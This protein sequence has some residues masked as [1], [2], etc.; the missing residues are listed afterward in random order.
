MLSGRGSGPSLDIY[1]LKLFFLEITAEAASY[2]IFVT[3]ALISMYILIKR[4]LRNSPARQALLGI[5]MTMLLGATVHLGLHIPFFIL[6]FPTLTADH[7][8]PTPVLKKLDVVQTTLRRLI[9]FL[10]D[11]VVVWRAWAIWSDNR[12]VKITLAVCLLATF[13]TSLILYVFNVNT[14]ENNYQYPT[15]TQNFLGTFCLLVTNATS[16]SLIGYKL[17]YYRRNLKRYLNR[18]NQ[19]TKVETVLTLL[20]ESGGVYC[21]FWVLLM[22]GDFGYFK[23]FG[24]EWFQPSVSGIYPT[25]VILVVSHRDNLQEDVFKSP[26]LQLGTLDGSRP[27]IPSSPPSL[28][29]ST[30]EHLSDSENTRSRSHGTLQKVN[31][32]TF[33]LS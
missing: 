4:G 31:S 20:L 23:N 25:V 24:F 3:V 27:W 29:E 14:I 28:S 15:L 30:P 5:V 11:V 10:S 17:W 12:I 9:Y 8:D 21:A 32:S 18:G 26:T 7:V 33:E 16:T 6:Q 1:D 2:G 13:I 19:M 22:V